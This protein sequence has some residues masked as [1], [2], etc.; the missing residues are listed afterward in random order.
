MEGRQGWVASGHGVEQIDLATVGPQWTGRYRF[1]WH[2][3]AGYSRPLTLG[4]RG[5]AVL[6]VANL[7]ARLDGQTRAL[8]GEQFN[9]ALQ[10]RVRLFQ[11]QEG[12]EDDGLVG[13][14]TLLRLNERLG[15]DITADAARARIAGQAGE[16][17]LR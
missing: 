8:A 16:V 13:E 6:Q 17:V 9:S 14:Q 4:D 11:R 10:R 15:I 5:E 2:P 7:F 3:P 12:L 1:L